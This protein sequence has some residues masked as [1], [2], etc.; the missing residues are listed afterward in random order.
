MLM[1]LDNETQTDDADETV[2]V[3]VKLYDGWE[4]RFTDDS[5]F[6]HEAS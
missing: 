5:D 3:P 4:R 6:K 2:D 1:I